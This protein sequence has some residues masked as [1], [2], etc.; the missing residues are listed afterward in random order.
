MGKN[1][2]GK[3]EYKSYDTACNSAF[4]NVRL[5]KDPETFTAGTTEL[6]KLTFVRS[7]RN[8]RYRDVWI[9]ASF[10]AEDKRFGAVLAKLQKGDKLVVEGPVHYRTYQVNGKKGPD[11]VRFEGEI[12]FPTNLVVLTD[13]R[14][15]EAAPAEGEFDPAEGD[16]APAGDPG[17]PDG[18]GGYFA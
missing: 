13:L 2:S 15:R 10:R 3:G 6:V 5:A 1:E 7:S 18:D 17:E 12:P 14:D 4:Y 8:D 9:T 16:S 11:A